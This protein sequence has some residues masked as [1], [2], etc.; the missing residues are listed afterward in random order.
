M[1]R[2]KLSR[3][4]EFGIKLLK[5]WLR[6]IDEALL[7]PLQ[8][9]GNKETNLDKNRQSWSLEIIQLGTDQQGSSCAEL[10]IRLADK[11]LEEA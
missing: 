11:Q 3:P 6:S 8:K 1:A 5:S 4:Q 10:P 9:A 7:T 2:K